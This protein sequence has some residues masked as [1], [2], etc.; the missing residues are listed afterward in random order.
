MP[1]SVIASALAVAALT[2]TGCA[3]SAHSAAPKAAPPPASASAPADLIHPTA[4]APADLIH[5][6]A[7]PVVL[8]RKQAARAYTRIVDPA[9]RLLDAMN[10]DTRDQ[11]PFAQ[12]RAD[13]GAFV[14]AIRKVDGQLT[15]VRWPARVQPY[16]TALIG[17]LDAPLITCAQAE[18]KAGGYARASVMDVE[19]QDCTAADASTI[20]DTIRQMLGLPPSA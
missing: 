15:A 1:R 14:A 18:A 7:R 9:N 3:S 10:N 6:P 16:I 5:P 11:A 19:R 8:T 20:P 17:T 4:S 12:F 2:A 13:A